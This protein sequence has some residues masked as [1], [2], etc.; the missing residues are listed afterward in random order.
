[1]TR[2][3]KIGLGITALA[4]VMTLNV[5]TFSVASNHSTIDLSNLLSIAMAD[6]ESGGG[7]T[8]KCVKLG[9]NYPGKQSSE[10]HFY[11]SDSGKTETTISCSGS[12][13]GCQEVVKK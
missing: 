10:S 11:C 8:S 3:I 6:A 7:T 4:V 12:G 5:K 13:G 2:K 1:M 9:S